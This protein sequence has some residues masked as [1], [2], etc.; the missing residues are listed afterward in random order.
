MYMQVTTL[1]SSSS[2]IP[3]TLASYMYTQVATV[4]GISRLHLICIR[5][6][7]QGIVVFEGAED[8][9]L[10]RIRKSQRSQPF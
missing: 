3:F 2:E 8:L 9:H 6:L 7:Q 5:K 1:Q 10:M 4:Y